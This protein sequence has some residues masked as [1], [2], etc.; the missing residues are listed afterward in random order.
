MDY[1]TGDTT[2][3]PRRNHLKGQEWVDWQLPLYGILIKTIKDLE[4]KDISKVHFGYI[5]LP[6]N[7][8]DTKFILANFSS[9]EH[10]AA[11]ESAK[12]IADRVL[13]G[14]FWPPS[15]K[16]P[17]DWD[18][19]RFITQRT[20]LRPWDPSLE[21]P[22]NSKPTATTKQ[23]SQADSRDVDPIP[24]AKARGAQGPII[25]KM[26]SIEPVFAEGC[27]LDEWFEPSM[28]LASAG[29]GKTYQLASRAIRLLFT[30]QPLDSI[31]AT[32]FTRKAAGEILHRILQW[33]SEASSSTEG[34]HRLE[35]VIAPMQ[36]GHKHARY[37]L[38]RLCTHLHRFRV[39]TLDSFYSQLAKSFALEL[40][41]P[42]GWTLLDTAQEELL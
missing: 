21:E 10:A 5:L 13:Q 41:L 38:A 29:T 25:P 7:V 37:Q 3:E 11:I 34:L 36:I 14:E 27:P 8:P 28:I 20:V 2:E 1:K 22:K 4:I 42:P 17:L 26:I 9:E 12:E 35:S 30:D 40:K 19:Y 39:S 6:K 15:D 23:E 32:T 16:I 24:N 31:L 18:D 33:L